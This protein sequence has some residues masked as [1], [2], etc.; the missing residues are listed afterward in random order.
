MGDRIEQL[1]AGARALQRRRARARRAVPRRGSGR[2]AE[3]SGHLQHA[4]RRLSC[5]GPVPSGG[6]RTAPKRHRRFCILVD[7][8]VSGFAGQGRRDLV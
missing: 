3:L 6:A 1:V 8:T 7:I 4:G 2:P 5:P